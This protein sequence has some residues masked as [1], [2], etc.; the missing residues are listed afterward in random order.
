VLSR[1]KEEKHRFGPTE[2][3]PGR[4]RREEPCCLPEGKPDLKV[5]HVAV[6]LNLEG[7]RQPK[8]LRAYRGTQRDGSVR[9]DAKPMEYRK[10]AALGIVPV[11]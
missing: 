8:R 1:I 10:P 5:Q 6:Q 3:R 2:Q 11:R 9:K 7:R 4:T